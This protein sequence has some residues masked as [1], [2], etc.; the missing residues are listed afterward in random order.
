MLKCWSHVGSTSMGVSVNIRR[1]EPAGKSKSQRT[2]ISDP[3]TS[4]QGFLS[5]TR[6]EVFLIGSCH[7]DVLCDY[8]MR[9]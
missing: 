4:S 6:C 5:I 2:V 3:D 7:I 8:K 1:K 9:I